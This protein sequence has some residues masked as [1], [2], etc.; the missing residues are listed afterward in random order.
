MEEGDPAHACVLANEGALCEIC[1]DVL[2]DGS[3]ATV[4]VCCHKYHKE[5]MDA[6]LQVESTT[7]ATVRCPTCRHTAASLQ[8]LHMTLINDMHDQHVMVQAV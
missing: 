7:L 6:F 4:L 1:Q 3:V 2:A 5:Y 8:D